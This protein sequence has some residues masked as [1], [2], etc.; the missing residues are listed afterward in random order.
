MIRRLTLLSLAATMLVASSACASYAPVAVWVPDEGDYRAVGFDNGY[1]RGFE[2][3]AEDA[4]AGRRFDFR[5]DRVYRNADWGYRSRLGPR[6]QYRRAFRDGYERGYADG[7]RSRD[8]A[9]RGQSGRAGSYAGRG[10][11][12]GRGS[13]AY[14]FGY[15]DGY[16]KGMEDLRDGDRYDL[17]RHR[18]YRDGD[19]HYDK[20][21]GPR[22]AY[23]RLYREGFRAGYETAYF[24]GVR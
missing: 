7:Y 15:Q 13:A 11:S 12:H 14:S 8:V 19:R 20:R 10:G 6:G 2:R 1:R 17:L 3:G 16:E 23:K 4:G 22:E 5:D 24:R 9:W 18:W 21:Y